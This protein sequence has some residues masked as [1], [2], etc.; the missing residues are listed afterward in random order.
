MKVAWVGTM[1]HVKAKRTCGGWTRWRHTVSA[2]QTTSLKVPMMVE[3]TPVVPSTVKAALVR[4]ME[5][6]KGKR[7][8]DGGHNEVSFSPHNGVRH[9]TYL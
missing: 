8:C 5:Y 2:R 3:T 7:T 6:V 9:Y 1:E 4:T